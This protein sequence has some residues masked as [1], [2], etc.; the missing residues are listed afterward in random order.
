MSSDSDVSS[1]AAEG[2]EVSGTLGG[3]FHNRICRAF[4]VSSRNLNPASAY[5]AEKNSLIEVWLLL[6]GRSIL[7]YCFLV[8]IFALFK[9]LLKLV[10]LFMRNISW[11]RIGNNNPFFFWNIDA[12]IEWIAFAVI[13]FAAYKVTS[14]NPVG[15]DISDGSS[16]P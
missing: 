3:I 16:T 13:A 6:I 14:I 12:F 4:F 11:V 1:D 2:L 7:F 10:E 15:Q 5:L 9:T 8:M